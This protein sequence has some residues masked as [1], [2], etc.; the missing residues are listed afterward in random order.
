MAYQQT[1]PAETNL[2]G[3]FRILGLLGSG[4]FANTYLAADL[5]LGREVAI[6]EFFPSDLAIRADSQSVSVKSADLED[7][8]Q[9]AM[10]RFVREAQTLAK[11]RH[12]SVVRV[13]RVFNANDTAYIVL[14]FVQGANMATWLKQL[15]RLPTQAELDFM[16]VP[17]LDALEVV[18]SSGILHRDIKPANIYV[19]EADHTPVLLDFGAA[20][21]AASAA[22]DNANTTAAIVSKGYSPNEAYSTDSRLQGPWTDLY[23]LAATLCK[24]LTGQPP[25]EATS[26]ILQDEYVPL[27]ERPE[28]V[29]NYRP[30]FLEAID[31]ALAVFPKHRPQTVDEFRQRVL[32]GANG[33][34]PRLEVQ[35][36]SARP[37][38][39]KPLSD[40]PF[41]Q[42]TVYS[43]APFS[44]E[45]P[46][47][48]PPPSRQPPPP[49]QPPKKPPEERPSFSKP[50]ASSTTKTAHPE[51]RLP[52]STNSKIMFG[53]G[54]TLLAIGA[55]GLAGRW[56]I[57]E[58][59]RPAPVRESPAPS[60]QTRLADSEMI[61][62]EAELEA[63]RKA[64]EEARLKAEAEARRKAD[65]EARLKAEAEARRKADEEARLEAEAEA[66]RKACEEA[67]E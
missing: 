21:Y 34:Q 62:R 65:E 42:T 8:F 53:A 7:R 22:R 14:E 33:A 23:G 31:N 45:A 36:P 43:D 19:R 29:E 63:R 48:A 18:H 38:E 51:R 41:G 57:D 28:L 6:K 11:F 5:S 55:A 2:I 4:G 44:D 24:A 49:S 25:P 17:L 32:P 27:A 15:G 9:W 39:W 35:T 20:K 3:E 1:L 56:L 50:E 59:D 12:P 16:L 54:L 10:G 66:R 64:E 60:G 67:P 61:R 26:R 58:A 47:E 13:F 30:Q 52:Q 46:A 37:T 40:T